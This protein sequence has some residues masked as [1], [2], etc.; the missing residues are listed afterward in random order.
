MYAF[1]SLG[2]GLLVGVF[3]RLRPTRGL[4]L[5]FALII[6]SSLVAMTVL[7]VERALQKPM[8]WLLVGF[9]VLI[10][11]LMP[12]MIRDALRGKPP[13]PPV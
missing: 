7:L 8:M 13:A 11:A 3:S 6:S 10:L 9:A 4:R 2:V 12:M 1:V 5:A